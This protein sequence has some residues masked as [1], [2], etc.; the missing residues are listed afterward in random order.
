[1]FPIAVRSAPIQRPGPESAR[2]PFTTTVCRS[3]ERDRLC[4]PIRPVVSAIYGTARSPTAATKE[5]APF[6]AIVGTTLAGGARLVRSLGDRVS[7][8]LETRM[9]ILPFVLA[10]MT[11]LAPGRDHS[12]LGG[13]IARAVESNK[14]LFVN[15]AD[16]RRTASL[17]VAVAFRESSFVVDVVGDKGQSFCAY[18]IHRSAGGSPALLRDVDACVR[19]GLNLLGTSLR[20][21]PSAPLAWYASGPLGCANARAQRISRDRMNLAAYLFARVRVHDASS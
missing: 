18:Q 6:C 21:C 1:M 9:T 11:Q 16:R 5:A 15:D 17:M 4:P 20:V 10:A 12:E 19:T 2:P 7:N 13:A 3:S 8:G 14:P